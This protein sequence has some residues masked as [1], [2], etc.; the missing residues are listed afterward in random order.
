[1][2]GRIEA[3]I[4]RADNVEII[5]D[6]IAG[7]LLE[8]SARQ[9]D[10]AREGGKNPD[11]FKLRVFTEASNPWE[12]YLSDPQQGQRIEDPTPLVNVQWDKSEDDAKSSNTVE[13]QKVSATYHIDCYG[14]GI[15]AATST[16]HMP[17]DQHAALEAQRAARLV[18][19][20]LMAGHY[21]YLGLRGT[22]WG[23]WR[24]G[25]QSF[26]P[27]R[28]ERPTQ[29]VRGVRIFLRVDFNEFS[30]QVE[31]TPLALI[32]VRIT[33]GLTGEVTLF[34]G[35]YPQELTP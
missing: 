1:M 11:D 33:R 9:Q 24:T 29:H 14:C 7:I 16:G 15:G 12:E 10:L 20:I 4:E 8:E 21:T 3:L 18:R 35:S 28:D 27:P 25:A 32:T 23:R 22:V 5:R 2:T 19:S 31:G 26:H 6:Q 30:P 34:E 17:S 13:R